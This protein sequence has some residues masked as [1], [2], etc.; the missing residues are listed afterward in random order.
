MLAH[1]GTFWI[2]LGIDYKIRP[3]W[4]RRIQDGGTGDQDAA[5]SFCAPVFALPASVL[6]HRDRQVKGFVAPLCS[7]APWRLL[8][9]LEALHNFIGA[10]TLG[11]VAHRL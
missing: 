4:A 5:P 2:A 11:A 6:R 10:I 9:Q 7:P 8:A 3:K 1:C